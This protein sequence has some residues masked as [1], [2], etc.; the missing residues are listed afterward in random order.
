MFGI[1]LFSLLISF[2]TMT[3]LGWLAC[4]ILNYK[5]STVSYLIFGVLGTVLSNVVRILLFTIGIKVFF[6]TGLLVDIGCV[7]AVVYF[8][9]NGSY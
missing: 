1:T 3:F 2:L 6:L 7:V 5:Y 8:L 4:K 9:R